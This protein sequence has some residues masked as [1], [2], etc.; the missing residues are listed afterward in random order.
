MSLSYEPSLIDSARQ[1]NTEAIEQLLMQCQ[2]AVTKFARKY[3]VTP[4][5]VEDAV[6][7]TLWIASQKIGSLR[8]SA[9][10]VGWLFRVVRNRCYRLLHYT[11]HEIA[12]D[13]EDLL[14]DIEPDTEQYCLLKQEVISALASLPPLYRQIVIMRDLEEMTA[15]EV[16]A[17]LGLTIETVKSRLH[18][19]RNLLRVSLAHW[20]E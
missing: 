14:D 5:D 20:V 8:V 7:E 13:N 6:Q 16:A 15:P 18:R 10:F 11:R 17:T 9:A 2:P 3:C 4:E 19:G 1:G 12:L